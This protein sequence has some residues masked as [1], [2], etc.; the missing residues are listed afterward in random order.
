MPE[1]R[2]NFVSH[3]LPRRRSACATRPRWNRR[4]LS[5]GCCAAILSLGMMLAPGILCAQSGENG[6]QR[7]VPI[8]SAGAGFITTFDSGDTHLGPLIVPVL[9]IPIGE[10][11]LIESRATFESDLSRPSGSDAFRGKVKKE[12]DYLQWDFIAIP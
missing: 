4:G 12:V 11:W 3:V 8:P 5:A 7:P 1:Q 9:L 10:R 6:P 2:L